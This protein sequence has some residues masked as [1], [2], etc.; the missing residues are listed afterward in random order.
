MSGVLV[1]GVSGQ[2]ALSLAERATA[3]K[4][5]L[6]FAGR[7]HLDLSDRSSLRRA[8]RERRPEI[9]VN[10][11]AYTAVDQAEDEPELAQALNAGGPLALAEAARDTSARLI[12]ISTDY[13]FGGSGRRPWREEDPTAPKSVYG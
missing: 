11:A 6:T 9:I 4:I 8:V 7:P 10:A 2:L 1:I 3:H 13:V 5:P 12:H